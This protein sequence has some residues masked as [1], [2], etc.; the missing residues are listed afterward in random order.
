MT[1]PESTILP[2]SC[3]RQTNT[4]TNHKLTGFNEANMNRHGERL[5]AQLPRRNRM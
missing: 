3:K 5:R 4:N 2:K 1:E